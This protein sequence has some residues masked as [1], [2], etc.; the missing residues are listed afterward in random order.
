MVLTVVRAL[1]CFVN[2]QIKK[3]ARL[4]SQRRRVL[5]RP[6]VVVSTVTH[7][8]WVL[9]LLLLWVP[10]V[11]VFRRIK[12]CLDACS[13]AFERIRLA[14]F[15]AAWLSMLTFACFISSLL[16]LLNL[17]LLSYQVKEAPFFQLIL[18]VK[19]TVDNL[20][21]GT[22]KFALACPV[23]QRM[24]KHFKLRVCKLTGISNA[25]LT[26]NDLVLRLVAARIWRKWRSQV[27]VV[28][29][30]GQIQ[31]VSF[32]VKGWSSKLFRTVCHLT[33]GAVRA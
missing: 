9:F 16:C 7:N 23:D 12:T 22:H 4:S 30:Q 33:L 1:I 3:F 26:D 25:A 18:V 32:R 24:V 14:L 11:G 27:P 17:R 15:A 31:K 2:I 10:F 21:M 13:V 5:R 8:L 28:A 6:R 29:S 20:A 19:G